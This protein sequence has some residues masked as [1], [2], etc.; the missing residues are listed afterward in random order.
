MQTF[1]VAPSPGNEARRLAALDEYALLDSAGDATFESYALLAAQVCGTPVAFVGVL[2]S[3]RLWFLA[4]TG[5]NELRETPRD[6]SFCAHAILADEMLEI[7]DALQDERF[8]GNPL[9]CGYPHIRS[10]AGLPLVVSGGNSLGTLCAIDHRPRTLTAEQRA[11]L[12]TIAAMVVAHFEKRRAFA[13]LGEDMPAELYAIDAI[14]GRILSASD[15]AVRMSGYS[16]A[17]LRALRVND[18]LPEIGLAACIDRL[19]DLGSGHETRRTIV[20]HSDGAVNAT[21]LRLQ[22]IDAAHGD[23]VLAFC[24]PAEPDP[25]PGG[26]RLTILAALARNLFEALDPRALVNAL[27][28]GV[29]EL[30][31]G[32]TAQLLVR[33]PGGFLQTRNLARRPDAPVVADEFLGSVAAGPDALVSADGMRA[34]VRINAPS[35]E[36][37]YVL[38]IRAAQLPFAAIDAFAFGLLGQY[39][40]VA[41]R[42]V[43][44]FGEL[45]SRRA[46]VVE[47]NQVKND[48]IAMLAHDFKGPLTT[49]VG[50]ADVLAE[51]ERFDAESR[52]LLGM[53]NSSAMRLASLATDTLALSR[54][55]QNELSLHFEPVDIVALVRDIVRVLGVT[56]I[57]DMRSSVGAS[58]VQADPARLRQVFENVIGNAIKYSPRG[59]AVDV[60]LTEKRGGVEVAVRDRG[61]GIPA[62]DLPKLFGRFARGSNA[63][64]LGIGGTGFGLYLARTIVER[65]GGTIAVESKV[66]IGSTFRVLVPTVPTP[67]R[68]RH[69]RIL[70]LDDEGDGRSFIAHTLRDEGYAVY[71]VTNEAEFFAALD[72]RP[73]DAA[74]VDCDALSSS[75]ASVIERV[76]RRTTLVRLVSVA[77]PEGADGHSVLRKPFL[78]KDLQVV[79]EAA[80]AERRRGPRRSSPD[81]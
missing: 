46:A 68:A 56:R 36:L 49:I 17:Q 21:E 30:T 23:T 3:D 7:P 78:I 5:M 61:I 24:S 75:A 43:E 53:I 48:L 59:D 38:E 79:V 69:R 9:V 55:D 41:I 51:D 81:R 76:G 50:L 73:Y 34:A 35:G 12:R 66:S 33:G 58:I 74:I 10:Y 71:P 80:V 31:A 67:Q 18:L 44:L 37:A 27:V 54:L 4:S 70:L 14:S 25:A 28:R 63:R 57:I 40:A 22:L 65:H 29:D 6:V 15:V 16:G 11:G 45:Q 42:N 47:L 60:T 8:A 20:K 64:E 77:Q 39:L 2:S 32:G 72:E 19:R 62:G 26:Q 13:R 52:R 1:H